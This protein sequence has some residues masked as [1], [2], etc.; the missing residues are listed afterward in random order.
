VLVLF[1]RYL[2]LWLL[3]AGLL[4]ILVTGRPFVRRGPLAGKHAQF[5]SLG[6]A[7]PVL[8]S[9]V[10][11]AVIGK[12]FLENLQKNDWKTDFLTPEFAMPL[13]LVFSASVFA[14]LGATVY[15]FIRAIR[16]INAFSG[17]KR[18]AP[19][20]ALFMLVPITNLIV[21]PYLEYFTYQRSLALAMPDRASKP[22]AAL[23]VFSA[24]ALLVISVACGRLGD[25]ASQS[26]EFDALSLFVLSLSTGGAG[27]I[28][29]TRIFDRINKAQEL[30]A[31]RLS[32]PADGQS[33]AASPTLGRKT[34]A[35]KSVGVAILLIA[36]LATT[37]FPTL[38]TQALLGIASHS[39]P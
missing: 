2:P 20:S 17:E 5:K 38:P 6:I 24:F 25:D 26:T 11:I 29:T 12:P 30:Y 1:F 19:Y 32:T 39:Q 28:L 9:L 27:G 33:L 15:F 36:A 3:L 18:R 16:N 31:Q 8:N 35:I 13:V 21:T 22:R 10:L 37:L 34:D 14:M 23:L 4:V 7:S